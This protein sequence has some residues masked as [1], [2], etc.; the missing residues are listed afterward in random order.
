MNKPNDDVILQPGDSYI[1]VCEGVYP[2]W[3][4]P[5]VEVR[6]TLTTNFKLNLYYCFRM[7]K[8]IG[9]HFELLTIRQFPL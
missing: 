7:T 6:C 8:Q 5:D 2:R 9:Q 1:L 4:T 3:T